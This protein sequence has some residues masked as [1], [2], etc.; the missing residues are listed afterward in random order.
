M[1]FPSLNSFVENMICLFLIISYFLIIVLKPK[2][3][4]AYKETD[5][6]NFYFFFSFHDCQSKF[7]M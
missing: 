1:W 5:D 2:S 7:E 4:W 6:G 3:T